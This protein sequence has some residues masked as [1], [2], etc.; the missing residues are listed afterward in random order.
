MVCVT[1]E[2]PVFGSEAMMQENA[3]RYEEKYSRLGRECLVI[4]NIAVVFVRVT[5]TKAKPTGLRLISV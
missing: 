3:T 5:Y 1:E 4:R 2:V